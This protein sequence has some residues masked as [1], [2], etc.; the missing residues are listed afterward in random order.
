MPQALSPAFAIGVCRPA[1]TPCG[2][3]PFVVEVAAWL[4]VAGL[5]CWCA[6]VPLVACVGGVDTGV[7]GVVTGVVGV[8]TGVVTGVVG[9]VTGVVGGVVLGVVTGGQSAADGS[10][11]C[12]K[13]ARTN[14]R[15]C[16]SL[17]KLPTTT[18]SSAIACLSTTMG[19]CPV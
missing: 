18:G 15:P 2:I 10:G 1:E 11:S 3:G 14:E 9:V 5:V 19:F 12:G 13:D 17:K 16:L 8:V 7:V 4:C 6:D